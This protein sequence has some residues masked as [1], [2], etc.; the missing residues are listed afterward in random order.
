[1]CHWV[2]AVLSLTFQFIILLLDHLFV[3]LIGFRMDYDPRFDVSAKVDVDGE[4]ITVFGVDCGN[5]SLFGDVII[6]SGDSLGAENF[7]EK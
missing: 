5:G 6:G 4:K 3:S 1:M 7:V 2:D